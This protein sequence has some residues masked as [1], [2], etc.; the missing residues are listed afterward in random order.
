MTL[1]QTEIDRRK[2]Y[3]SQVLDPARW[4]AS[5][6]DLLTMSVLVENVLRSRWHSFATT[7]D[8]DG[9]TIHAVYLMLIGF[10]VEN[11]LK[12]RI[13]KFDQK[14]WR[15]KILKDGR[16]PKE[17]KDKHNLV[18]LAHRARLR[19][20]RNDEVTLRRLTRYAQWAG[21]YP[22]P[23]DSARSA[24]VETLEDGTPQVVDF[25]M[26]SDLKELPKFIS[27]LATTF[28]I[29]ATPGFNGAPASQKVI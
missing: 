10:A 20:T 24:P 12:S 18:T 7:S 13:V 14:L 3:A 16:L 6:Q 23:A 21:R 28:R 22:V 5:A 1:R 15:T 4:I 29:S 26:Q 11:L 19:L 25:Q 17:L 8:A 9:T 27:A 2:I